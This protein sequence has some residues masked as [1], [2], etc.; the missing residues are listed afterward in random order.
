MDILI[1]VLTG[2]AKPFSRLLDAVSSCVKNGSIKERIVAQIGVTNFVD[3]NI[4]TFDFADSKTL[5]KLIDEANVIITHGGVGTI[6][7][8]LK[9]NKKILVV[10][11]LKKYK[12]V[13]NDHQIQIIDEFGNRGCIIPVYDLSLLGDKIK[14]AKKFKPNSYKSNTNKFIKEV[15]DCISDL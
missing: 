4:E 10:P 7:D 11:R 8:C 6:I 9:K 15:R 12:E 2:T 5:N 14:D 1:L 13:A 3:E